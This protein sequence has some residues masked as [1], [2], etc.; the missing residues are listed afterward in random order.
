ML[1][2]T[3]RLT[4]AEFTHFFKMGKRL[5]SP[6]LTVVY[7]PHTH[8]QASAV[9]SKKIAKTAVLRNKF[10]RR[11]YDIFERQVR[12]GLSKGVFIC[13][14]KGGASGLTYDALK[15]ELNGLIHKTGVLG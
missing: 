13:I 3:K 4:R 7:A 1:P 8:F 9:I 2:R 14:A 10:R 6:S 15:A 5:H 11:V 12:G